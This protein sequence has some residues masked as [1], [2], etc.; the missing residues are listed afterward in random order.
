[1]RRYATKAAIENKDFREIVAESVSAYGEAKELPL[2]L[3]QVLFH[4]EARIY[5]RVFGRFY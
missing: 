1:V 4:I 3:L 2:N 5:N